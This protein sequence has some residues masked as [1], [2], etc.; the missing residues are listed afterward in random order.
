MATPEG[1]VRFDGHS[2]RIFRNVPGDS[3]SI[4]AN[5]VSFLTEDAE[6]NIWAGL[7]RG[8]ACRY[9]RETGRFRNYPFTEKLKIKTSP[10]WSI[11]IDKDEE[12]WLG[13]MNYGLVHL[14]KKTGEVKTFDLVT[15][16]TEPK[17]VPVMLPNSNLA[18]TIWQDEEGL[19]WC[20]TPVNLYSFNPKTEVATPHH[21][22]KQAFDGTWLNGATT[23]YPEGDFLWV[24]GWASG[25]RRYN[26]KTGEW[27]QYMLV[28]N[29]PFPDGVNI[30]N[31]ILP[32]NDD[33][34]WVSSGDKG[35]GVFNKKTEKFFFFGQDSVKY[36][37]FPASQTS[38][39]LMDKQGNI[40]VGHY[41]RLLRIQLKTT[42][43]RFN[44]AISRM[45][46]SK[47]TNGISKI[48]DDRE[49]RFRFIGFFTGDGLQVLDKTTGKVT[50][51]EF[52]YQ[53]PND[54][55]N[56]FVIDMVEAHDGTVWVLCRNV[57]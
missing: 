1:L 50:V 51:P 32:K 53:V 55:S 45:S 56:H 41:D 3:T 15:P 11:F 5:A 21:Y 24:G 10:V 14:D 40:W 28:E 19:L 38:K 46:S 16:K 49:G 42:Q 34:F 31:G 20:A 29:P 17:L 35:I 33:E 47:G 9:D 57:L 48:L 26:R 54:Q 18:Q 6:G 39:M 7:S 22:D 36:H 37:G 12:V 13:V 2:F 44:P 4:Y 23:F 8:G 52:I 27:K 25:L 43:F 30:L